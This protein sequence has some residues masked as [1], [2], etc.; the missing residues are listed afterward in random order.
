MSTTKRDWYEYNEAKTQRVQ[1]FLSLLL[2]ILD[3]VP[4]PS[5]YKGKGRKPIPIRDI[6]I[7]LSLKIYYKTSFR[8]IIGEL[9]QHKKELRL[10]KVPHFNTLRRYMID[11]RVTVILGIL[12]VFLIQ[13]IAAFETVFASD[14]TGFG[15]SRKSEYFTVV[16]NSQAKKDAKNKKLLQKKKKK[17][18]VKL[19]VTIGTVSQMV[20]CAVSTIG[21]RNDSTQLET[22]VKMVSS[23]FKIKEWLGDAGYLSRKACN[24][25]TKQHG[26]PFFWPKSNS[27]AKSR[28]SY[29]WSD[30]ITMFKNNLE[31]FKKHYH[32][33]SKVESVFSSIKNYFGSTV[34]SRC[35][36]GQ[37]NEL[38]FKVLAYNLCRLGEVAF[39]MNIDIYSA[40]LC[41]N[42]DDAVPMV[43][44]VLPQKSNG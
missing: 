4:L 24:L 38:L 36:E 44:C 26:I 13:P 37:L 5:L 30:M 23:V 17:D 33:R 40:F 25:V 14:A 22:M 9:K 28:G 20:V 2:L 12:L 35:I 34:F 18:F 27:T 31:S 15:T 43:A 8:D 3:T 19:H 6:I 11:P 1:T 42:N 7:C 16:L 29:A 32:Q 21:K 10:E 41:Q 39:Y